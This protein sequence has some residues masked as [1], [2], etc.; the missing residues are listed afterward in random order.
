MN[1]EPNDIKKQAQWLNELIEE[2]LQGQELSKSDKTMLA[3]ASR[4][5]R[6]VF[7]PGTDF[8][9][10]LRI[11]FEDITVE[12]LHYFREAIIDGD[13]RVVIIKPR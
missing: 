4:I 1:D 8:V 12:E 3:E 7:Y 11:P 2:A 10:E 6:H 5:I 13:E 9:Q